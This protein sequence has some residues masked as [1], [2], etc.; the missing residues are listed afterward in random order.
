MDA[1][2][3]HVCVFLITRSLMVDVKLCQAH[4]GSVPAK[5]VSCA[6]MFDLHFKGE[7]Q[8]QVSKVAHAGWLLKQG[9][10]RKNWLKR[11]FIS[12]EVIQQ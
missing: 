6:G 5:A 1:S 2:C 10:W 11:W 9:G 7:A 8:S 12:D 4:G 3:V